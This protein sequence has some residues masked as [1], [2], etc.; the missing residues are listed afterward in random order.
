MKV[1]IELSRAEPIDSS[2]QGGLAVF[3]GVAAA[4]LPISAY[5]ACN[6]LGQMVEGSGFITVDTYL[7]LAFRTKHGCL[8]FLNHFAR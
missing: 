7:C 1:K 4:F 2:F 6:T 8:L 5:A 3:G